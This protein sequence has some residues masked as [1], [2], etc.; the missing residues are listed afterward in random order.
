MLG[1]VLHAEDISISKNKAVSKQHS[2]ELK[3]GGKDS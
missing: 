2:L 3:G 1:M